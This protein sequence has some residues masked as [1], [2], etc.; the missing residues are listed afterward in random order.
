MKRNMQ[1]VLD[2]ID[3]LASLNHPNL[4]EFIGVTLSV[5]ICDGHLFYYV[6]RNAVILQLTLL[7]THQNVVYFIQKMRLSEDSSRYVAR[8]SIFTH[9]ILFMENYLVTQF[10]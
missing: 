10:W 9:K 7:N 8:P 1:V 5:D 6:L 4:L 3:L 2:Q